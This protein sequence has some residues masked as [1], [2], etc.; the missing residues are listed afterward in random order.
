VEETWVR[1]GM[2]RSICRQNISNKSWVE[3]YDARG[4]HHTA[5]EKDLRMQDTHTQDSSTVGTVDMP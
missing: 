2:D 5:S 3:G 4:T 1:A